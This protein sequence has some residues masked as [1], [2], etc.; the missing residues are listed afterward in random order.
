M[1]LD[2]GLL[3]AVDITTFSILCFMQFYSEFKDWQESGPI[4]TC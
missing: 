3:I 4:Y 2:V 1:A